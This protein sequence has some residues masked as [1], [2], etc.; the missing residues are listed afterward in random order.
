VVRLT[1]AVSMTLLEDLRLGLA[2]PPLN[3]LRGRNWM[4][5]RRARDAAQ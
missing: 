5:S 1:G 4:L 2:L 3:R